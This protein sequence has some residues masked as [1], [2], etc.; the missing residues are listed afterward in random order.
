ME[1]DIYALAGRAKQIL[2]WE[3]DK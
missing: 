3:H 1:E 2:L